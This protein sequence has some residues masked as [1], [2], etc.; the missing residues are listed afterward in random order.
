MSLIEKI[1]FYRYNPHM[2][3]VSS[4]YS[5]KKNM[6]NLINVGVVGVGGGG[7]MHI[8]HY[9]WHKKTLVKSI[10]D[11]DESRYDDIKTRFPF[12]NDDIYKAKSFEELIND[13][14]IDIISI[15]TPDHTHAEYAIAAIEAG[16]HVLVEKPMCTTMEDAKKIIEATKN[17]KKMFSV[18]Q[19]MR[20]VKRNSIIKKMIDDSKLGEISFI[21]IGY[22]HDMRERAFEFSEWRKDKNNF[23]HP[24]FGGNH[25]IDLLRWLAG[26]VEE[27]Y[28]TSSHK[29]LPNYP[30]DDTFNVQLKMKNGGI[31]SIITC[32][33]PVIPDEYHPLT[34]Y[35]T[36]GSFQ[37]NTIF[38]KNS[39][40]KLIDKPLNGTN[41]EDV[42]QF[43]MQIS[44]FI[45]A[46][47]GNSNS[48]VTALDGAKT[49]AVCS[50]AIDSW[51]QGRPIEVSEII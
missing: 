18:F 13:I 32:F 10:Y 4:R 28:T 9:L 8:S 37:E 38:Y 40:N 21:Q 22:I 29:G 41:Y 11:I 2:L 15:A 16:K 31:G 23:Q 39:K 7:L 36:K 33:S 5:K 6:N 12:A 45:D 48:L 14:D 35:G 26:E 47:L 1:K 3:E 49:V 25:N 27:V 44:S 51:K 46:V 30:T 34:I 17:S 42:P 20:F 43:R 24:L 50:A 19:Q